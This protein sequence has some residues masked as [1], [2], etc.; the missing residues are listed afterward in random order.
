MKLL[1]ENWRQFINEEEV[2]EGVLSN[3]ALGLATAFGGGGKTADMPVQPDQ[4][5]TTQVAQAPSEGLSDDGNSFTASF[6]IGDDIQMALQQADMAAKAGLQKAKPG[7]NVEI[8]SRINIGGK[9][10]STATVK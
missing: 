5:E 8:S 10:F 6:E 1:M 4:P 9:M 7:K 3:V 2:D